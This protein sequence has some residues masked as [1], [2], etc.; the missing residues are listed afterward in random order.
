MTDH[1]RP[2]ALAWLRYLSQRT[3]RT[4]EEIQDRFFAHTGGGDV[5]RNAREFCRWSVAK[6][7]TL[8]GE[9]RDPFEE[10]AA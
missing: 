4:P 2:L 3:K 7:P 9:L 6:L 8:D 10:T 1:D 5:R